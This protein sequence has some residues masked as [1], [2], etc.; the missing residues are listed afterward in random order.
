M[1][2]HVF[3]LFRLA[4]GC[5]VLVIDAWFVFASACRWLRMYSVS[6]LAC[7]WLLLALNRCMD[8]D[9]GGGGSWACVCEGGR[10]WLSMLFVSH[11]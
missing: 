2:M 8:D 10:R 11:P 9:C 6:F 5:R 7:A 4:L 3:D 1:V